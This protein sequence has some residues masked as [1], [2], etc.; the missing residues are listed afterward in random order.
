MQGLCTIGV[1]HSESNASS[2][3]MFKS[4]SKFVRGDFSIIRVPDNE[5]GVDYHLQPIASINQAV[6][7]INPKQHRCVIGTHRTVAIVIAC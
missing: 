5:E 2:K 3:T 7:G 1:R 6:D 4:D